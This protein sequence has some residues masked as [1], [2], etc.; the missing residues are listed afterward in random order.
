MPQIKLGFNRVPPTSIPSLQP[1]YDIVQGV[2]LRDENNNPIVTEVTVPLAAGASAANATS[3]TPSN[4]KLL[5]LKIRER[6]AEVSE[7]STS[8]LGIPRAE[9]QLSLFADVSTYGLN[10][11]EYEFFSFS[12][13][14]TPREWYT[15]RNSLYGSHYGPQLVEET[16]E[17]ALVVQAY[18]VNYTFAQGPR[19]D[20]YNEI[21]YERF[22]KFVRLGNQL[23]EDYKVNYPAFARDKFLNPEVVT[24]ESNEVSY[25]LNDDLSFAAIETWTLT[26]IDMRDGNLDDP[27]D[28]GKNL[29]F[30]TG[31]GSDVTLPGS[32]SGGRYFGILQSK[33]FYRYQPGRI[34]GFTFGFKCSTDEASVDNI[35]EWGIGNPTDQYIFQV[36]GAA[37][38]IVRRSVIPLS[39]SV[40]TRQGLLV[41][42][43]K[44]VVSAEPI[45]NTSFYELVIPREKFNADTIDGNGASGYLV[46]PRR[47]TMYKI[48]FGW[49]GAIGAKFFAYIPTNN[50]G[51]RWVL[52]HTL[53]VENQLGQPCLQ[54]P[55]FK[56]KYSL[57]ISDTSNLKTPQFL[58][59]YGASCYID[60]GD[61]DSGSIYS[62]SSEENIVNAS[63]YTPLLGILPKEVLSNT[64]GQEKLNKKNIY[65]TSL[66]SS[67][68]QLTELQIVEVEGCPAFGHHYAPSLHAKQTGNS[69]GIIIINN[70]QT[71]S[72]VNDAPILV[73]AVSQ[74]SP[75]V[76]TV[77]STHGYFSRQKVVIT[78]A[79]G[80]TEING[81]EYYLNVLSS[82][83]FALY[84]NNDLSEELDA[85]G[86]TAYESDGTATGIPI[87][88]PS[89]DDAKIIN[90]GLFGSYTIFKNEL[91]ADIARITGGYTKRQN[92]VLPIEVN[93][94]GVVDVADIDLTNV[95]FTNFDAIATSD[96]P[97]TGEIFD[98]N[99]LNPTVRDTDGQFA[100][101]LIGITEYKPSVQQVETVTGG[102]EEVI[103]FTLKDG[104]T[105]IDAS[106]ED[107]LYEEFTQRGIARDRDGFET[108]EDLD[109]RGVKMDIDYRLRNPPG[110]DSGRCSSVRF[111]I[112]P[113]VDFNV[114]YISTNPDN[115]NPGNFLTFETAPRSLIGSVNL[116]GGEFGIGNTSA[117]AVSSGIRF[118]SD[119]IEYTV[120]AATGQLGYYTEIADSVE[121]SN[122][123]IWL[124]PV[125]VKDRNNLNIDSTKQFIKRRI[126]SF[127]PKPFYL[128]VRLRD[129]AKVN[130]LTVTE[131]FSDSTNSICP[132]WIAND[133]L[134]VIS[135]GSSQTGVPAENFQSNRL[136][137]SASVATN[138]TQPLRPS[139]VKDTIYVSP[140]NGTE[141]PL[142]S[143]Y[144]PDRTTI[145]SGLL[146]TM[147]TFVTARSLENNNINL[148]NIN[149]NTKE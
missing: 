34:S 38:S 63:S 36:R 28:P 124:S 9:T 3:I 119:V 43:Q 114:T 141:V 140:G 10:P 27:K 147:A 6:F 22:V 60:G 46:N 105:L 123:K 55:N 137:E 118:I 126:F 90:R 82:T 7:V 44:L 85:T 31:F 145:S 69:R 88:L 35:I 19:Y 21:T 48:E 87:F 104:I 71:I 112:E 5:A 15:R 76:V 79:L 73:T 106:L 52:L 51:A 129:S 59:K 33:K 132:E 66:N 65:L 49:Y 133:Q 40:I 81:T 97:L 142:T 84:T 108:Q 103:K 64:V 110:E 39:D 75:A 111:I 135:S 94:G 61:D 95:R 128:V 102:F 24:V 45:N 72:V 57:N 116:I 98:I 25:R 130:N 58:Y 67:V 70:G 93:S 37:L 47:V 148:V 92:V 54:D 143:I 13:T 11:E 30:L 32:G 2:P 139:K 77:S 29:E 146:N 20:N 138:I 113:R 109:G 26:W 89:D 14:N 117:S 17:Q 101:F 78:D 122:F 115:N 16:N 50:D 91:E 100:E 144:G 134:N 8:L 136:L 99:F 125:T 80:M 127:E 4:T 107:L 12:S 96:Y 1:L 23:F 121:D 131:Y 18:P 53:V 42:D 120:D 68:D 62:Y 83:T 56:F 86:F 41:E 74:E 149:I